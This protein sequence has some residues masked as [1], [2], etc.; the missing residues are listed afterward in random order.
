M[1]SVQKPYRAASC[2]ACL[3]ADVSQWVQHEEQNQGGGQPGVHGEP[4]V[5]REGDAPDFLSH[6]VRAGTHLE[7][8]QR[9]PAGSEAESIILIFPALSMK[10]PSG[11]ARAA[12]PR[13]V[14]TPP[15]DGAPD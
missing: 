3:Y 8:R 10:N 1:D 7:R 13:G 4:R 9:H 5:T 6:A 2:P 15:E 14:R 12:H 11:G